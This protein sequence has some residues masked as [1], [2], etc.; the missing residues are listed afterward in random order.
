MKSGCA[1]KAI[2]RTAHSWTC[3]TVMLLLYD[4]ISL[5]PGH[6]V[7]E[8]PTTFGSDPLIVSVGCYT[9]LESIVQT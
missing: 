1:I 4:I 5:L 2:D 8:M 9:N 3:M 7:E 6:D